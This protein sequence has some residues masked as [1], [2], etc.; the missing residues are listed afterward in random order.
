M[1]K[2]GVTQ[3][4]MFTYRSLEERILAEHPL[5]K[6]RVLVDGILQG[7][8]VRACSLSADID[9]MQRALCDVRVKKS[10]GLVR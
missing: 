9:G 10:R 4:A 8:A 2:I 7:L 1:R 6:L 3:H 5:H